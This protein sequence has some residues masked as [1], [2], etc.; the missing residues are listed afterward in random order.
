MQYKIFPSILTDSLE[1]VQEQIRLVA[2]KVEGVQIDS[3]DGEFTDNITI[4]PIDLKEIDPMGLAIDLHLMTNDP[5]NDLDECQAVPALR[6]VIAQVEHMHSQ[7]EFLTQAKKYGW[8]VGFSLDLY[9]P[10]DAIDEDILSQLDLV[11]VMMIRAGFQ[12]EMFQE[13][14]LDTVREVRSLLDKHHLQTELWVDGGIN[15]ETWAL[16]KKAGAIAAAPGSYLWESQNIAESLK[17]L[18]Y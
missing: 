7:Q 6:T 11:Q 10:S 17:K 4:T 2:G 16:C 18:L 15:P 13:T 8:K 12:G 3:I 9:T 1:L 5:I 14:A